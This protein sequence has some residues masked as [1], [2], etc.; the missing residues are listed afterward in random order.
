MRRLWTVSVLCATLLLPVA[1]LALSGASGFDAVVHSIESRYHVRATSVP[2]M[3]LASVITRGATK[4]GVG[5]LR[6][7]DIENI[8]GPVDADELNRIVAENLGVGWERMI[9]ESSHNEQTLIFVHPQ[10]QRTRLF[11]LDLDGKEMSFIELSVDPGHLQE[12]LDQHSH[13]HHVN[14]DSGNASN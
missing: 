5:G 12:S 14:T 1:V 4:N 7:A 10:G 3:S 6:V 13:H 2:F 9:R 8:S 11:I